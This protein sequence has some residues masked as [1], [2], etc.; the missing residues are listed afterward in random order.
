MNQQARVFIAATV[1]IFMSLIFGSCAQR[2]LTAHDVY[3]N[4]GK[5][6]GNSLLLTVP[7]I[8][9]EQFIRNPAPKPER[10][11]LEQESVLGWKNPE[12]G[13]LRFPVAIPENSRLSLRLG[14]AAHDSSG[15]KVVVSFQGK[16]G[17]RKA[18]FTKSVSEFQ[19]GAWN[20]IDI[21]LET[22]SNKIGEVIFAVSKSSKEKDNPD[23]F[24]GK[25]AIYQLNG[26]PRRNIL[27]IGIDTLRA[28]AVSLYGGRK[29]VTPNL[30]ELGKKATVFLQARS[31]CPWTLPS[32]A[33]ML[34]GQEPSRI[35]AD[36]FTLRI[37]ENV[38]TLGEILLSQ[39]YATYA[40]C[41]SPFLGNEQSGFDQGI[42]GFKFLLEPRAQ[43]QVEDAKRYIARVKNRNWFCFIHIM[44]PHTPYEPDHKYIDKLCDRSYSGPY[45]RTYR[46]EAVKLRAN[47]IPPSSSDLKRMRELYDAEVANVDQAMK[48]LF[49][50]LDD[51]HLTDQTLIIL[52][53][54]HGEEFLEHG[55]LEHG[56][57][58]YDE[59]VKVPL[60]IRGDGFPGGTR[61]ENCV[62]NIDIAPTILK[63]AG[64]NIPDE[65]TGYP[66][67]DIISGIQHEDRVIFGEDTNVGDSVK[68]ALKWPY[69]LIH[70]IS[71]GTSEL[72]D[73]SSD[74][75]EKID[76][77]G[78]R[79]DIVTDMLKYMKY[80]LRP[81]F[82]AIHVFITTNKHEKEKTFSGRIYVEKGIVEIKSYGLTN[83]D[84]YEVGE[85][86]VSFSISSSLKNKEKKSQLE[87]HLLGVKPPCKHLV[88]YPHQ[89][90]TEFEVE[91]LV[92]GVIDGSRFYPYGNLRSEPSGKAKVSLD[93][94]PISPDIPEESKQLPS[95]IFIW[96]ITGYLLPQPS[97]ELD[98][99]T[100][101]RLRA[102]GYIQE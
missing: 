51:N 93:E 41:S 102:L 13:I 40:V 68:Y 52:S 6:G 69:K 91:A 101:E 97:A 3:E 61:V 55:G 33:S 77:A 62:A 37:P 4:L 98:S 38:M 47:G 85:N 57:S 12:E 15:S 34:C 36:R 56:N 86:E 59:L 31:Q 82:T 9:S 24:W 35:D 25:P 63:Y 70:N 10:M 20:D 75:Y 18:L 88:I 16:G 49:S 53:S 90:T 19:S 96:A 27:L 32:F 72:Y 64:I 81:P 42:E 65:F 23:L 94:F 29:E 48:D 30:E 95:S 54:D 66:L 71:S 76:L 74:P 28:D 44:D 60:I 58:Q 22:C 73:L 92:D 79:E 80:A 11:L 84:K 67:Q 17:R 87:P 1:I 100:R 14:L 2:S 99:E 39:G 45:N 26:N 50:F 46:G 83:E 89:D 21:S 78:D 7:Y 8:G 5:G 43:V